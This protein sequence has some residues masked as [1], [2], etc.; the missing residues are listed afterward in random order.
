MRIILIRHGESSFNVV[1]KVQG[2]GDRTQ[3]SHLT[4]RGSQ[5]AS[6]AAQALAEIP[7]DFAYVSP[8]YRAQQSAEILLKGRDLNPVSDELLLEI[9]LAKWEGLFFDDIKAQFPQQYDYW[10]NSPYQLCL[11]GV[12]PVVNLFAQARQFW[13]NLLARHDRGTVLIIAHSGI[14]RALICTALGLDETKYHYFQQSNCGI[15]VLN[16]RSSQWQLEAMNVTSHLQELQG[17]P[18]PPVRR[19]HQGQRLFL[20][21]HGETDWNR[22]KR[23]QGQ[24]DIPLNSTGKV[25]ADKTA[26]LLAQVQIDQA[27][28]S[29]L[30]RPKQTAEAILQHH[31]QVPLELVEDLREISHGLWEGKLEEEVKLTYSHELALW[32]S[33]PHLVQMPEGENLKQVWERASRGWQYI[34]S[35]LPVGATGLVCAHDAVNKAILSSLFGLSPD[36]FWL[37]K[38]GN[39]GISVIDYAQGITGSPRLQ[40]M[41]VTS[42]V[43]GSI[44]DRTAAGAL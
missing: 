14:N 23:F 27:W 16:Y 37:F 29:P 30:L 5:Q 12:Y 24:M 1:S 33:R 22:D 40:V 4:D 18:F 35:N 2:R 13:Q 3:H 6:L 19:N 43:S 17:S 15:T 25:Q 34:L 36:S 7:I 11:D 41:N 28:S 31:P 44:L 32:Q 20:V 10:L 38:Q 26:Q 9:D 21:R 8:L 39:G 42:H